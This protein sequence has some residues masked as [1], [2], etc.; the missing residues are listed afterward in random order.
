MIRIS[1][2]TKNDYTLM[3]YWK[4][5]DGLNKTWIMSN[6]CTLLQ[7]FIFQNSV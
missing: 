1:S 5:E 3:N 7:K 6:F 4:I 2:F